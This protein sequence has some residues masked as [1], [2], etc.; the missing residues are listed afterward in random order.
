M[1][2]LPPWLKSAA[3]FSA[4]SSGGPTREDTYR[5][6]VQIAHPRTGVMLN[7]GVFDKMSGGEVD[8]DETRYYPGGMAPPIS[9]GGRKTVSNVVVSRIYKLGRDHDVYQQ[10]V[11][12]VGKS[13][14]VVIKQPLDIDANVYGRPIVYN[15]TL[16]RVKAPDVDSETSGAGLLEMEFTVEGFP[17]S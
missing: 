2:K 7:Y 5:V 13:R 1:Q 9:L 8:S 15:C 10:L 14:G 4:A 3:G 11:N 17:T 6:T 16:K 12:S